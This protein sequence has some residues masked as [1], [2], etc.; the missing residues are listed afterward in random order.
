MLRS[1]EFFF[2]LKLAF[3]W[4]L[5]PLPQQQQQK[6]NNNSKKRNNAD[7]SSNKCSLS[8]LIFKRFL[9]IR[10]S[11]LLFVLR[12][13]GNIWTSGLCAVIIN[14][15]FSAVAYRGWIHSIYIKIY[16]R[17]DGTFH[18]KI[19]F[20]CI[21]LFRSIWLLKRLFLLNQCLPY[22]TAYG[23]GKIKLNYQ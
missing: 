23:I 11:I 12:D 14:L 17:L 18:T 3:V 8:L 9:W 13:F 10:M 22:H 6:N 19:C 2:F 1:V 4:L 15:T 20:V 16:K 5:K 7:Y 21:C